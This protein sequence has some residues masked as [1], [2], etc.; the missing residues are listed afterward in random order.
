MTNVL[1]H[2]MDQSRSGSK[3]QNIFDV[4]Q[5]LFFAIHAESLQAVVS[6]L[7]LSA[8]LIIICH[9]FASLLRFLLRVSC[10]LEYGADIEFIDADGETPLGKAAATGNVRVV[11]YLLQRGADVN[12]ALVHTTSK[13]LQNARC[14]TPLINAVAG[15]H[16]NVVRTLLQAGACVNRTN[17]DG[18]TPLHFASASPLRW[19][20][21]G[22]LLM[23]SLVQGRRENGRTHAWW[24]SLPHKH[25]RTALQEAVRSGNVGAVDALF[26]QSYRNN[27]TQAS[28]VAIQEHNLL[29]FAC[30][31]GH[32]KMFQYLMLRCPDEKKWWNTSVAR[33]SLL[34]SVCGGRY[35]G[36]PL[37]PH[38]LSNEDQK[39]FT[40]RF[41]ILRC[42]MSKGVDLYEPD[43]SCALVEAAKN[44]YR[45]I[46]RYLL[47]HGA[48]TTRPKKDH[49][50]N[51]EIAPMPS[52]KR[53]ASRV[54]VRLASSLQKR[55][56]KSTRKN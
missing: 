55:P 20:Q 50:A 2:E 10:F 38:R 27:P 49:L 44:G 1:K 40:Q 6:V 54:G 23:N 22:S 46:V 24:I 17:R 9:C 21:T 14:N 31:G 34:K 45:D 18:W 33:Q 16:R 29:H 35:L 39:V 37:D 48:T 51:I 26:K 41:E 15:G 32:W 42:L 30:E 52:K 11:N 53:S 8:R 28:L 43:S 7:Y 13:H 47:M 36:D 4:Q 12:G 25:G 19:K 5:D 56:E 3:G